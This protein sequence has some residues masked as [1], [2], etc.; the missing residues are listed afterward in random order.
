MGIAR[1]KMTVHDLRFPC[2]A[3]NQIFYPVSDIIADIAKYLPDFLPG[4][5]RPGRID[6]GP[7]LFFDVRREYRTPLMG[8]AANRHHHIHTMQHLFR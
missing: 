6:Y 1:M 8:M 5:G 3:F 4:S 2:Y 7:M